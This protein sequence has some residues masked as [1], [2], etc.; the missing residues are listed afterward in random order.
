M[1]VAP[2]FVKVEYSSYQ[3]DGSSV[4]QFLVTSI[5]T[6][7]SFAVE[8]RVRV[9]FNGFCFWLVAAKEI[10]LCTSTRTISCHTRTR[11]MFTTCTPSGASRFLE[12]GLTPG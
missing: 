1:I 12:A 2:A 11:I 8:D 7:A 4:G 10:D 3:Q 6:H 9:V 5:T